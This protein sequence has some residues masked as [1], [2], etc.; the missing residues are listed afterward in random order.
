MW[1]KYLTEIC[2]VTAVLVFLS[3]FLL[4]YFITRRQTGVPPGPAL[5]PIIGNIHV[6]ATAD[7]LGKLDQL[8]NK[9]GDIFGIYIGGK[10]TIFLNGHDAIHEA[11]L[12]KGSTFKQRPLSKLYENKGIIFTNDSLWKE[13]RSF[14]QKTFNTICFS[15][16]SRKITEI[17]DEEIKDI[18]NRMESYDGCFDIEDNLNLSVSNVVMRVVFNHRCNLDDPGLKQFLDTLRGTANDFFIRDAVYKCLPFLS[19]LPAHWLKDRRGVL[20]KNFIKDYIQKGLNH[21]KDMNE[22]G[23]SFVSFYS[24]QIEMNRKNDAESTLSEENMVMSAY[25]L[26]SAGSDTTSGTIR[27]IILYL[28]RNPDIQ[29]R[30]Y[31]EIKTV[32]GEDDVSIEHRVNLLYV[33]A[34]V[35]EGLRIAS[36]APFGIPHSVPEDVLFRG[37]LFPK[38]CSVISVI[39]SVLSDPLVWPE[40]EKFVPSRFLNDEAT[41]LIVPKEFIPFS[42]GPRS[43]VGETLARME[44]FLYVANLVKSF[45]LLPEVDGKLPPTTGILGLTYHPENFKM[46]VKRR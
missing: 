45:I 23:L 14:S 20:L 10:L 5:L 43:C 25:Q 4:V 22:V 11:F 38:H 42:L 27:W 21:D 17:I 16:K 36:V 1:W 12:K 3:T 19:Y 2:D 41:Q 6:L 13:Q 31:E 35:L 44:V 30:M 37:Y 8:R 18:A 28:I 24:K 39:S 32:V 34:V 40:P 15:D 7:I 26:L 33:Q 29:H 46:R 9:Y